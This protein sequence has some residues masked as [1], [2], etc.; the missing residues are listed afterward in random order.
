MNDIDKGHQMT[1][2]FLYIQRVFN[3]CQ[4]LILKIDN[5]LAPEWKNIYGNRIT[6]DVTANIQDPDR[7]LVEAIFRSYE[8][9]G[10]KMINKGITITFWGDD[11]EE[12][13]ITAG[14]IIYSDIEKR[15]HWDL[16]HIWFY[17]DDINENNEYMLD[18]RM[19]IFQPKDRN[20]IKEAYVFSLPLVN[21]TD[22]EALVEKIIKPLKEL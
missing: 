14:K 3:E 18:G 1:L 12:P 22:E 10:D 11:I 4:R 9:D 21:I 6:R 16:W 2:A 17:W 15:N 5:Q 20:Y 7:W 8:S 13:I 19:N